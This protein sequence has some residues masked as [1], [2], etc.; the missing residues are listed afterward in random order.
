MISEICCGGVR[1]CWIGAPREVGGVVERG[2]VNG[3]GVEVCL[4]GSLRAG[5][6]GLLAA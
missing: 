3:S 6:V 2:Y 1:R 5:Q 4:S